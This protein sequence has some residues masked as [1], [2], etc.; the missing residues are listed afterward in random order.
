MT[1]RNVLQALL[2][3]QEDIRL[4]PY[5]DSVGKVT[6]GVGRNLTDVGITRPEALTLLDHDL[7]EC[8]RDLTNF[9]W[10]PSMNTARQMAVISWRFNLG[11]TRFRK[12]TGTFAY[13]ERGDYA[14][15]ARQ[16]RR[17]RRYFAQVGRRATWIADTLE[18]GVA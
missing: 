2:I 16:F 12:W 9:P 18:T 11:P 3:D 14:G 17:N 6:I 1:D 5:V 10:Y 15:A 4:K 7:D 8:I 13:L